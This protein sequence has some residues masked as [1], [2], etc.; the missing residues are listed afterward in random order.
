MIANNTDFAGL[1]RRLA[2]RV[3][4]VCQHLFPQG[5]R[6][7]DEFE[8]GSIAGEPGS[9]LKINL[10][11]K[12]GL[13][14]DFAGDDGGDLIDLW[15]RRSG[16]EKLVETI[17]EIMEW[18]G[19]RPVGRESAPRE[20]KP[21]R[22]TK[23]EASR[24]YRNSRQLSPDGAV[25]RYLTEERKL[26][27]VILLLYGVREGDVV[28]NI[29]TDETPEWKRYPGYILP[30]KSADG[31]KIEYVKGIAL[32]RTSKGKKIQQ[33]N[34]PVHWR[35]WGK[36]AVDRSGIL[37]IA[38]GEIEALTWAQEG[39]NAVSVPNGAKS[40]GWLKSEIEFLRAFDEIRIAFDS[41]KEGRNGAKTLLSA[42]REMG[43]DRVSLVE[44]VGHKDANAALQA[45]D[46]AALQQAFAN[47]IRLEQAEEEEVM[48]PA[49]HVPDFSADDLGNANSFLSEYPRT[50]AFNEEFGLQ[51]FNGKHWTREN[52][53]AEIKGRMTDLLKERHVEARKRESE[54]LARATKPNSRIVSNA[55]E[56]LKN[57]VVTPKGRFDAE[58]NLRFLAVNNGI[59]DLS[60]GKL[61]PHDPL[62]FHTFACPTDY[63]PK[64]DY[65]EWSQ[66]LVNA[67]TP[68]DAAWLQLAV[69]M[70]IIGY[71]AEE[72]LVYL[73]GLSRAGKGTFTE[74]LGATFGKPMTV[75]TAFDTFTTN[76]QDS[77]NF[78]LAPMKDARLVFASENEGGKRLNAALLKRM[79][80]G[81]DINCCFKHREH[82]TYRPRFT[83]WLSANSKPLI[84]PNDEAAWGRLRL[85]YF[86]KSHLGKEDVRLKLRFRSPEFRK[87]V[88]NWAVD[89]AIEWLAMHEKG[90]R[91]PER[92]VERKQEARDS[93]DTVQQFLN[94][95]TGRTNPDESRVGALD[96]YKA[97]QGHCEAMGKHFLSNE[98]FAESLEKKG[99]TK[100]RTGK[101][102]FYLGIQL[103]SS[104]TDA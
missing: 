45:G 76:Q 14:R 46:Q 79:T 40:H 1:K 87:Q 22:S 21:A 29:G 81:N 3:L 16:R 58:A 37:V 71:R 31:T 84:D 25:Y 38:E 66:W 7:G 100:K 5:K 8:V 85:V 83:I 99:Y 62:K 13:W 42:M 97:Y 30:A 101:G 80:G 82:F 6:V 75:E 2:D 89:G 68:E 63:D 60:T 92:N 19:D 88:L 86:G 77:N 28:K 73:L 54:T 70:S 51:I 20:N 36:H 90:E 11:G 74:T 4:A 53:E 24:L 78:H 67:T 103:V 23:P 96:L 93:Q 32:E 61:F 94:D 47:P 17:A 104:A 15:H 65:S 56:M 69:G 50:V 57:R 9:S 48:L 12:A 18:L 33:T 34:Q 91:L 41:D 49:D 72:F 44:P 55:V 27:P 39:L 43:L 26:S 10:N 102:V 35:L 95:R 52:A 64:A 59:V 98:L